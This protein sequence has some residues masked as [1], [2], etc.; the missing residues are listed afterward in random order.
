MRRSA[1][2]ISFS[3]LA[4]VSLL[5]GTQGCF[6]TSSPPVANQGGGDAAAEKLTAAALKMEQAA[7]RLAAAADRLSK[8]ELRVASGT[9]PAA[10][11]ATASPTT[12]EAKP[13]ETAASSTEAKLIREVDELYAKYPDVPRVDILKELDGIEIPRVKAGSGKTL[14]LGAGIPVDVGNPH[15]ANKPSQPV[16]GDQVIVRF[17]SEPKSL[18]PVIEQSAVQTYMGQYIQEA[19]AR[20]DNE[21]FEFVPHLATK[22]IIEDS[23]KLSPDYPGKKYRLVMGDGT[24]RPSAEIEYLAPAKKESQG[25]PEVMKIVVK[26][27]NEEGQ[28][29]AKGW[30]GLFPIG[31]ILGAPTTGY[32]NWSNEQGELVISG[33]IPGKY[34]VL[35]GSEIYGKV[36]PLAD[37]AIEVTPLSEENPLKQA[38]PP[39][40]TSLVLK[41]DEYQDIQRETWMTFY[42]DPRAKWS[43]GTPFTSTDLKFAF[44]VLNNI[45]VDCDAVRTYYSDLTDLDALSPLVVRMRYRQQYFKAFEFGAG[46]GLY[47][48]PFEFF[49]NRLKTQTTEPA[50]TG[51]ELTLD[52]LTEAEED[53]QKKVSAHGKR[54]GKFFNLDTAYNQ[55][56]LGT[57]PYMVESWKKT[58]RV[59]LSRNDSYWLPERSGYLDKLIFRFLPDNTTA[60]QSLRA[61]EIDF[62]YRMDPEQFTKDL[63]GPPDWFKDKFIKAD[64]YTPNYGYYCW[65]LNRPY[66]K[67]QRVRMALAML[68]EKEAFLKNKMY[69]LG[70][71]VSGSQYYFGPGY[72]HSVKSVDYSPETARDLLATA[73]WIDTNRDGILDRDGVKLS[74]EAL[75]PPGNPVIDD[76]TALL[77]KTLKQVGIDMQ[78]SRMEWAA[79]VERLKAKDFD[80]VT[81]SWAMPVESDPFQ[82]W[83]S[84]GATPESRGSNAG[85]FANNLA[86]ELIEKIRVTLEPDK[87]ALLNYSLHRLLDAQQPYLFLYC[88]KDL[89][90]YHKRFRGVKWYRLRPGFDLAE[91]YVPK[92]EQVH[93][94]E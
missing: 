78:I 33:I 1:R 74:F 26:T 13:A 35:T 64:W 89:G 8:L 72:D 76:R 62:N 67:D 27:V 14:E 2:R 40:Q 60:L 49:K 36:K 45:T 12:V 22:W 77:Q 20:Q 41:A 43:D 82:L 17:N 39:G 55:T 84:S 10:S 87:R 18:N 57:G 24:P 52:R 30:V 3:G 7:D 80:V 53:A 61:G 71:M 9:G 65:N 90:A 19:L 4:I 59:I 92:D 88:S 79:F 86:D 54:F 23:V 44:A 68:F 75:I 48:P 93:K 5:I 11:E 85:S 56:P 6:I 47:T 83:H 28:P 63:A 16:K 42:L 31:K 73:G 25:E 21:T 66:F 58:D 38:L 29:I 69:N 51:Y 81:L 70:T 15:A 94:S 37:G 46:I 50:I 32:H 34:R 91:W